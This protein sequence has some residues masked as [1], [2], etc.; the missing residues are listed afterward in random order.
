[1]KVLR[2]VCYITDGLHPTREEYTLSKLKLSFYKNY[3]HNVFI[4]HQLIY[5][6]FKLIKIDVIHT[7]KYI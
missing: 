2:L 4:I 6:L 5:T 7:H 1:M 3:N